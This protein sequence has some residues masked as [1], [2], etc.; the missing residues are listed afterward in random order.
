MIATLGVGGLIPPAAPVTLAAEQA[1]ELA[2]LLADLATLARTHDEQD[3][4]ERAAMFTRLLTDEN[5]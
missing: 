5:R 3:L 4:A 2:Q 1:D